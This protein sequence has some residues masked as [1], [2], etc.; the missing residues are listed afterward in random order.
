MCLT[1]LSEEDLQMASVHPYFLAALRGR[2]YRGARKLAMCYVCCL[3]LA[4]LGCVVAHAQATGVEGDYD[5]DGKADVAVYR[6]AVGGWYI[7]SSAM[8]APLT[9]PYL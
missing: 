3:G 2:L 7:V 8:G 5:G 9:T 4:L 1:N 6:P